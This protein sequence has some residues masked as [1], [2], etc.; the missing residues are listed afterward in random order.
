[1]I[2]G[3]CVDV[4]VTRDHGVYRHTLFHCVSLMA[5]LEIVFLEIEDVR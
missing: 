3:Q 4:A 5:L 2:L 1:M